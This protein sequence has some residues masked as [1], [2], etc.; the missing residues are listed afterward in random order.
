MMGLFWRSK[1][2]LELMENTSGR[3]RLLQGREETEIEGA[4]AK[5]VSV[6]GRLQSPETQTLHRPSC[7][8]RPS[9]PMLRQKPQRQGLLSAYL[10]CSHGWG[11][12]RSLSLLVS[13]Q[14]EVSPGGEFTLY[15][16]ADVESQLSLSF[17]HPN[18]LLDLMGPI[19]S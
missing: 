8:S 10:S 14:Q 11:E 5:S 12:V 16:F 3:D 9:C 6:Q 7:W 2:H 15:Q 17:P 13:G 18:W 1:L 4:Y 19:F